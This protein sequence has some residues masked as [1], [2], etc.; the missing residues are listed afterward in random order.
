MERRIDFLRDSY[1]LYDSV[2]LTVG[3]W[4]R[5]NLRLSTFL[6]QF[7]PFLVFH[8]CVLEYIY[9]NVYLVYRRSPFAVRRSPHFPC[10]S[11]AGPIASQ[12]ISRIGLNIFSNVWVS[13]YFIRTKEMQRWFWTVH[14]TFTIFTCSEVCF[15]TSLLHTIIANNFYLV[16]LSSYALYLSLFNSC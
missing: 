6:W 15:W 11:R 4:G 13:L 12:C 1:R 2:A 7:P 14:R 10:R 3:S 16:W 8:L 9:I 5:K